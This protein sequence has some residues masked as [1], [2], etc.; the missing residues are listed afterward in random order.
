MALG[1]IEICNH[2][3]LKVGADTIASLDVSQA[4]DDGVIFSAKLC[5]ILFDQALVETLRSY[6]WNSATKR[7]QLTRLAEAPAFKYQYK[8]ALPIDYVRLINLYASTEAYDDTTEWSI[9]SGEVLTDYDA[10]YLKYVAKPEDVSVL[11][12]LAQQAVI[13]NL[14]MKLAVPMH[15]DEKLKNNLLTELQ[16][17]ILPAA[18]SIDT[19]ENKNWDNEE[20]NFLVSRNYSSPII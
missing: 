9:E 6:N 10:A 19:I 11:D 16:T 1:K 3:L 14:A 7:V 15:L 4:T 12:P 8:Y 17:I 5:N 20:S 13:C 2:A 18:R